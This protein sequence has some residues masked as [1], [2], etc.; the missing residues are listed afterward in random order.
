MG[1][2]VRTVRRRTWRSIMPAKERP[3]PPAN[4]PPPPD[5]VREAHQAQ[6]NLVAASLREGVQYRK[7]GR[8]GKAAPKRA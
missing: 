6:V 1:A 4:Q 8:V 5:K 2:A 7:P 3:M